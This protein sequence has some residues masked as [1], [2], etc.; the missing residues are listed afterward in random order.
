MRKT[1]CTQPPRRFP[2]DSAR[3]HSA[4]ERALA[5]IAIASSLGGL[6][7]AG[8]HAQEQSSAQSGQP[9]IPPPT[10]PN[11]TLV[12]RV[13]VTQPYI[14]KVATRVTYDGMDRVFGIEWTTRKARGKLRVPDAAVID[15]R[16]VSDI[17]DDTN[18]GISVPA[19]YTP[20]TAPRLFPYL[21][22][23]R[24][25]WGRQFDAMAHASAEIAAIS[26]V[27]TMRPATSPLTARAA[28]TP[29]PSAPKV[30]QPTLPRATAVKPKPTPKATEVPSKVTKV[31]KTEPATN[32]APAA[33]SAATKKSR[34]W[35]LPI[36]K[37]GR[38]IERLLGANLAKNFPVI[39]RWKNG[40]ATSIKS[41]NIGAKSYQ[42]VGILKSKVRGY[43][44]KV[45]KFNGQ[46]WIGREIH[47]ADIKG[48]ALVVAIPHTGNA[49]QQ[50]ALASLLKYGRKAGVDVT[51]VVIP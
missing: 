32:S 5:T 26:L 14:D 8:A 10:D 47:A 20:V 18:A 51:F 17:L 3:P 2:G 19:R 30:D 9:S 43:V 31:P 27:A 1:T 4:I 40:I 25:K 48:R 12:V 24:E 7:P 41:L 35:A 50:A 28:T 39:D 22:A 29:R 46:R 38:H 44:D 34:I 11:E 16:V 49:A 23:V 42:N 21:I 6:L 13:Q 33:A 45:A 37:R 36:F 15:A